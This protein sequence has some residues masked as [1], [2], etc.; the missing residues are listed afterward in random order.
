MEGG[1]WE[2]VGGRKKKKEKSTPAEVF[3]QRLEQKHKHS[4][5]NDWDS[6]AGKDEEKR[7]RDVWWWM[8]NVLPNRHLIA[9]TAKREREADL[10]LQSCPLNVLTIQHFHIQDRIPLQLSFTPAQLIGLI[11]ASVSLKAECICPEATPKGRKDNT[12][13]NRRHN[14]EPTSKRFSGPERLSGVCPP[15]QRR[16][17]VSRWPRFCLCCW[18]FFS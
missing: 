10:R 9:Q 18:I 7:E 14:R 12:S 5:S 15:S 3:T 13:K 16:W 6:G 8:S 17:R 2:A 1:R 11:L 4:S